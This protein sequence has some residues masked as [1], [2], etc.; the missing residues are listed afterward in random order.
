[1]TNSTAPKWSSRDEH[2]IRSFL[3]YGD[4]PKVRF[5]LINSEGVI[6]DR[7]GVANTPAAIKATFE[8]LVR[9][10]GGGDFE[11]S[12]GEKISL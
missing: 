6:V 1:M 10:H 8:E 9:Q 12:L 4:A 2:G 7:C 11:Y 5:N 3:P